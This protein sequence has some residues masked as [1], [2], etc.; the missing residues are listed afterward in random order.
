MSEVFPMLN[1]L[2]GLIHN[3]RIRTLLTVPFILQILAVTGLISWLS[4]RNADESL[5]QLTQTLRHEATGRIQD[6]IRSFMAVPPMV[7]QLNAAALKVGA[8]LPSEP[9]N[10][11]RH[12]WLAISTF[13]Q[14]AYSYMGTPEG[15]FYGARRLNNH[16]QLVREERAVDGNSHY[17]DATETGTAGPLREVVKN[18]DPR[19]RPW[20]QEAMKSGK[21]VWS[22]I[23]RHFAV[24]GLAITAAHPVYDAENRLLAV[25][26]VDFI[27]TQISDYLRQ[28]KVGKNGITFIMERS[29]AIVASSSPEPLYEMAQAKLKRFQAAEMPNPV[30]RATAG[31]IKAR[32]PELSRITSVEQLEFTI[33]GNHHYVQ[34]T[35]FSEQPGLDWLILVVVPRSDFDPQ[36][37]RNNQLALGLI[38]ASVV[39]ASIASWYITNRL[40]HPIV[41]L[42]KAAK[43]MAEGKLDETVETG[44]ND[45]LG[46][47]AVSFSQMAHQ[48]KAFFEALENIITNRTRELTQAN[49][50]LNL[51]IAERERFQDALSKERE[52]LFNLLDELPA[53][54]CLLDQ[55]HKI[56]FANRYFRECFG[57]PSLG[58]CHEIINRSNVPCQPCSIC[59]IFS[60]SDTAPVKTEWVHA[61]SGRV[62]DST[63]FLF[64][65]SDN[66]VLGLK[67]GVDVTERKYF[68]KQL[69]TAR[70][71][72]E[73][74]NRAKSRF[75]AMMSHEIRTPMNGVLGMTDLL[76]ST[77]LNKEQK[78]LV[79]NIDLSGS[80][81]L[82]IINQILDFSKIEAGQVALETAPFNL[83]RQCEAIVGLL[84]AA[85][86]EKD[87]ILNLE[88]PDSVPHNFIGDQGKIRQVL[89]N[90]AGNAIK[91]T[92]TG[93][94][95]V[96]VSA[97]DAKNA[98]PIEIRII[99]TGIGIPPEKAGSLF[100][101]FSQI[102][103]PKYPR[104]NGTGLGLAI[105]R[106]LTELMQGTVVLED[107]AGPGTTVL[108]TLPLQPVP[109][110][111]TR[112]ALPECISAPDQGPPVMRVLVADDNS[113][114]QVVVTKMLE[115][116]SCSVD[117][118]SDGSI[119]LDMIRKCRYDLVLMDCLMPV[120]SGFEATAA[121][122]RHEIENPDCGRLPVV[123]L[124]ANAM[125]EDRD[126]C[127]AAGMDYFLPKPIRLKE[128]TE[129]VE[130]IRNSV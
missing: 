78:G 55:D 68:E 10:R 86:R 122:R 16:I 85:A 74:A 15:D 98:S 8:L 3:A 58:L 89:L 27:L 54:I 120:M 79:A 53:Y 38:L 5:S 2:H 37:K 52:R 6:N 9:H 119:A 105:S 77:P 127:M 95:T 80:A 121:I 82:E 107:R 123:A 23:Y 111:D 43:A 101:M 76:L 88:Y 104:K 67:F 28:L 113:I 109:E 39:L 20:Y 25:F 57:D 26:G 94:V 64:V 63:S 130:R 75:L 11:E 128:L 65:D 66:V 51:E 129:L 31:F 30:I 44:R 70:L 13:P 108:V 4:F 36:L 73:E 99:D 21:P 103:D 46:E 61:S 24:P 125:Q 34:V 93:S 124:T 91:F 50:Q 83:K 35:P 112:E 106:Q 56:R 71:E 100:T 42:N 110:G 102:N 84:K 14:I 17:L 18:F 47:L 92:E 48:L 81:L 19:T 59:E 29:G 96:A 126:A 114:N 32:F 41:R 40:V 1:K 7:N 45:E 12:F 72:A 117:V 33:N 87:L 115:R 90:L 62:F 69:I 22:P 118:A 97:P 116:L 49:Q 60:K